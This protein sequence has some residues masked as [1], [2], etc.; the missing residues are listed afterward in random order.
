MFHLFLF[1]KKKQQPHKDHDYTNTC[2]DLKL[3]S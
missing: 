1:K 2:C 3:R